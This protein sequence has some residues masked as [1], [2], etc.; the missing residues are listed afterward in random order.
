ML[1]MVNATDSIVH[2][3][4]AIEDYLQCSFYSKNC[5]AVHLIFFFCYAVYNILNL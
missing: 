3:Y 1:G 5:C 2:K 4:A